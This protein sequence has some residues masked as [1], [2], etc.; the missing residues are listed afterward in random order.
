MTCELLDYL[1]VFRRFSYLSPSKRQQYL[2]HPDRDF[3]RR[4]PLNFRRT[5]SL[6]IGLMRKSTAIELIDFFNACGQKSVSKSAFSQRRKLIKPDFFQDFFRLSVRQFYQCFSSFRTWRGLRVF[7]VDSTGQR[8]PDEEPIGDAFGWHTNQAATVPSVHLLFT[9]DVLNKIIFRVDLHDQNRSEVKV[10]YSNVEK[11]PSQALYIYDRGHANY[12]LPFLHQKHGSFFLIRMQNK[13]SPQI[14]DFLHSKENE[15]VITI[16]LKDRAFRSLRGL[17]L[18]PT[19]NAVMTVRLVRV[20]L[21]NGEVAVLLT[22]MMNRRRFHY[23]RIQQLYTKRWGVETSFFVLKSFLMLACFSAYTQPG[24][25]QDLWASFVFYNL[26]SAWEFSLHEEV[27]NRTQHRQ[28]TYQINRNI[29]AGLIKR[30]ITTLFLDAMQKWRAK[31]TILKENLLLHLEPYRRRPSRV[32]HRKFMRGQG[33]HI[34]E[35]NYRLAL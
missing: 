4:S 8:L 5:V 27:K 22:N 6:I 25:E 26:N 34:F 18:N 9:F 24:V 7:A 30:W 21:P 14:I 35:F 11:L 17:G 2:Y 10:A 3:T 13:Q 33:R 32:R 29:A 23:R 28:Y 19:L 15:G 20:D 31:N 1:K 12:G 16:K